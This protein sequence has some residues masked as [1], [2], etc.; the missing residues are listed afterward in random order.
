[1]NKRESVRERRQEYVHWLLAR[2][3]MSAC[4]VWE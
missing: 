1:M 4:F 2:F 3:Y